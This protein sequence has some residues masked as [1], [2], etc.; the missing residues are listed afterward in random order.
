MSEEPLGSALPAGK[1]G[2][3]EGACQAVLWCSPPAGGCFPPRWAALLAWGCGLGLQGPRA[4]P[5]P[6]ALSCPVQE[7]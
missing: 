1:K 6:R 3:E 7:G 4:P 2:E 5:A